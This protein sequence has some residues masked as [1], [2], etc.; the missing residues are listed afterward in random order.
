MSQTPHLPPEMPRRRIEPLPPPPEAFDTVLNR[1]RARRYRRLSTVTAVTGV[2]LAGLW[3]GLAMA[4]GV[5]GVQ[6]T[7][8]GFANKTSDL[9]Q[10]GQP[11]E[12]PTKSSAKVVPP[13]GGHSSSTSAPVTTSASPTDTGHARMAMLR[14]LVV[15]SDG[16]PVVGMFVY[17]G[18]RTGSSFIPRSTPSA[19]T[20]DH[21]RYAVPCTDDPVLLT[22]WTLNESRAAAKG[23]WAATYVTSPK[24]STAVAS[25]VTEVL[26]S[27][28]VEG[29]VSTDK[30]CADS[31][32]SLWLWLNS[33]RPTA[34]ELGNL[35]EGDAFTI[36][37]LPA[38][39]HVLGAPGRRI[40]VTVKSGGHV[41]QD[42]TFSCPDEPTSSPTTTPSELPTPSDSATPDPSES[43]TPTGTA[44]TGGST[45]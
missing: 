8:V 9:V 31:D 20:N 41:T 1:A 4:G 39:T 44:A 15:D 6:D 27:A 18:T 3:G 14:G 2:F 11:T 34:V 23:R 22:P 45:G 26:P 32:F 35:N 13:T 10:A 43:P 7:V 38:G 29:H 37:G 28:S 19:V 40:P 17:T 25:T 36:S 30:G 24:C 21:G 5:A 42:V 16:A 33:N 12:S